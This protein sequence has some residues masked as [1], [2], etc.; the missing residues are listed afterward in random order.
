MIT[1]VW[2]GMLDDW[3]QDQN[4]L[5]ILPEKYRVIPLPLSKIVPIALS[6]LDRNK[7]LDAEQLIVTSQNSARL[8]KVYLENNRVKKKIFCFGQQT[9]QQIINIIDVEP[10]FDSQSQT[11]QEFSDFLLKNLNQSKKCFYLAAK[12]SAYP[13]AQQLK[14]KNFDC[15]DLKVYESQVLKDNWLLNKST[16]SSLAPSTTVFCFF[17]PSSVA[18]FIE[19]A[20]NQL[21]EEISEGLKTALCLCIGRTTLKSAGTYFENCKLSNDISKQS[22][23]ETLLGHGELA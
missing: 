14:T 22:L 17:S 16:L 1:V 20:K 12:K 2:T 5:N 13:I 9:Y 7:I 15:E 18:T 11:A 19:L 21:D 4:L 6:D 3:L 23:V 8:L 10:V